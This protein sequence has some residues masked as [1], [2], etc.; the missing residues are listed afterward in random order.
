MMLHQI[1]LGWVHFAF[2]DGDYTHADVGFEFRR[3]A[4]C[5]S[6]LMIS[7]Y[8]MIIRLASIQGWGQLLTESVII[9]TACSKILWLFR[10]GLCGCGQKTKPMGIWRETSLR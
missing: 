8:L 2:L 3:I 6:V 9:T 1:N 10:S 4:L 5:A 7:G